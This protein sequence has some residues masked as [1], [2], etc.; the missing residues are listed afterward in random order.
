MARKRKSHGPIVV[1]AGGTGGHLF[2]AQALAQ[3]LVSRGHTIHLMTDE[4]VNRYA[5]QFP[6]EEIHEIRSATFGLRRP[7]RILPGLLTLYRGYKAAKTTMTRIGAS[8]AV[9]FGGYPTLPPIAAAVRLG[10][11]TCIHEQNAVVGRANRLLAAKV[12][13][14]AGAFSEPK[15]L[16]QDLMHKFHLT[17]NPVRETAKRFAAA[18]YEAPVAGGPFRLVVFGGSQGARIMSEIVPHADCRDDVARRCRDRAAM[19]RRGSGRRSRDLSRARGKCRG[20]DVL[21]RSA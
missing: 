21:L 12:S 14:I 2:P 20:C 9:G 5:G 19:P 6:A 1:A 18:P 16:E 10:L 3:E 17:G 15:R 7:H 4:R 13:A 8:A 11:P